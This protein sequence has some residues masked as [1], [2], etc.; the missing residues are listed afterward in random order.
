MRAK[1]H[2]TK[3]KV[4]V[5]YKKHSKNSPADYSCVSLNRKFSVMK[6][7]PQHVTF[8]RYLVYHALECWY[9]AALTNHRERRFKIENNVTFT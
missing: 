3:H 1:G 9:L 5:S 6:T 8:R 7:R 2:A 4:Y